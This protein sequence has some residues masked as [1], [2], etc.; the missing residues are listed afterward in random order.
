MSPSEKH[1][2]KQLST[3]WENKKQE[4]KKEK[5]NQLFATTDDNLGCNYNNYD[6]EN[7]SVCRVKIVLVQNLTPNS[8][9]SISDF[10]LPQCINENG[11]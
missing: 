6:G 9:F 1:Q 4:K 8:L 7:C 10:Y 3:E 11:H 5:I 2:C